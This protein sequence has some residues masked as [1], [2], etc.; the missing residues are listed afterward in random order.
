MTDETDQGSGEPAIRC[1]FAALAGPAPAET[2]ILGMPPRVPRRGRTC[3]LSRLWRSPCSPLAG[4]PNQFANLNEVRIL[5]TRGGRRTIP[6]DYQAL[7]LGQRMEQN[8]VILAGD[9]LVVP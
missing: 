3:A 8:I 6:I 9:N 1:G 7:R 4:E 5:R 2:A